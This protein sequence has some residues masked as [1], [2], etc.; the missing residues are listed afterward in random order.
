[1]HALMK[2]GTWEVVEL[3]KDQRTIC[4]KWVFTV[5]RKADGNVERYKA[6][7]VAKGFTQTYGID[8]QEIFAPV[9]KINYIRVLP[10]LAININWTLHQLDVK[11]AFLNGDL[12]E[13]CV[14]TTR[15]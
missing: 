5:K 10:S 3:P 4:C 2:N 11:N 6:R 7:L 8:Y 15:L 13:V 9:A 1:M 14:S 12:V